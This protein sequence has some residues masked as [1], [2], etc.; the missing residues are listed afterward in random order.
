M[1]LYDYNR[2]WNLCLGSWSS[3]SGDLHSNAGPLGKT[4]VATVQIGL[5]GGDNIQH[6]SFLFQIYDNGQGGIAKGYFG[7]SQSDW[8]Q[9]GT[10][11]YGSITAPFVNNLW[12][13][14]G[15]NNSD[16]ASQCFNVFITLWYY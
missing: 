4:W 7:A 5:N 13:N 10:S 6:A 12:L 11:F 9:Q 2:Y 16:P 14:L 8:I 1:N 3:W 15:I